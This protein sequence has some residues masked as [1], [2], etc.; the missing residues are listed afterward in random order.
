MKEIE[1]KIPEVPVKLKKWWQ[2]ILEVTDIIAIP[3]AIKIHKKTK[4]AKEKVL[5][6]TVEK[7]EDKLNVDVEEDTTIDAPPV[8]ESDLQEKVNKQE[9][10]NG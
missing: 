9:G 5:K 8:T 4:D 1:V 3:I 2:K 6:V 10:N 7:I